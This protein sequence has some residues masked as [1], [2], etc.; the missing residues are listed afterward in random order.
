MLPNNL[1][2][3]LIVAMT[4]GGVIG[5][6]NSIPWRLPSDMARFKKITIQ[7]RAVIMGRKTWESLPE[8][9]RP[10]PE[11]HNIVLT[12]DCSQRLS[13]SLEMVSSID[14]ALLVAAS[15]GGRA[16][17]I[18]GSEI[19]R[20]FLPLVQKAYITMVHVPVEGDAFFPQMRWPSWRQIDASPA[21]KHPG[22][23]HQTSFHIYERVPC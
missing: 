6:D 17:I 3:S 5:R 18:G 15:H 20:L 2:L 11:R 10:L 4:P 7:E 16:C 14:E 8:K 23:E 13:P 19:Y 22:D 1:A 9:F 21:R 12:R